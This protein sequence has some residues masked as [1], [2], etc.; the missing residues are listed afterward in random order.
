MLF[1]KYKNNKLLINDFKNICI[2]QTAFFGDIIL[3]AYLA[4][5]IK[6]S[7]PNSNI[8]FVTTKKAA[9]LLK[10]FSSV[11]KILI[12]DKRNEDK[13]FNGIK[14]K[15]Q[16]I[17]NNHCNL[18]IAPH[19][20]FR[21]SI[22]TFLAKPKF[23][24]GFKNASFSF[25]Y[26]H[27]IDY[28]PFLH[29]I[30]R[31]LSLLSVFEDIRIPKVL[32]NISFRFTQAARNF[33]VQLFKD[34]QLESKKIICIAPASVWKTKQ[35]KEEYYIRL[36][37]DLIDQ[38]SFVFVIGSQKESTLCEK[39]ATESGATSLAGQT[40]LESLLLLISKSSLIITNDSSP[41]HFA[42]LANTPCLTIFG[43]TVP[44][45]GFYPRSE[46]SKVVEAKDLECRPCSI[47]GYN[48]CP[49]KHHNCMN[50]IQP[51]IVL[52]DALQLLRNDV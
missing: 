18:I 35:W 1:T 45:F 14:K 38:N 21:T 28:F 3:S 24:I 42:T 22:L 48:Y 36:A 23:S 16:N 50:L 33:F 7:N 25:L 13:G 17:R 43:P 12:Y 47:H 9:E 37:K 27:T 49:L 8:C 30:E 2:I 34:Y 4:E 41:T 31:V 20:S 19:R 52:K 11:D 26:T 46:K 10:V 15:A 5:I 40:T 51:E 44:E 6:T 29:E 32:P 39:I